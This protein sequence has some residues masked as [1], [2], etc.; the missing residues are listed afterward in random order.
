MIS[1]FRCI[2]TGRAMTVARSAFQRITRA[3]EWS[4]P[5]RQDEPDGAGTRDEYLIGIQAEATFLIPL[6]NHF[7]HPDDHQP[8]PVGHR[9]R[10][11]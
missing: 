11:R 3:D 4:D 1:P 9:E 10:Q 8:R 6:G 7:C 5:P 2:D